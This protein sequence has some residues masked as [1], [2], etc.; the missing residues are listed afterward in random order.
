M[1][2]ICYA[3][4]KRP[5]WQLCQAPLYGS[6]GCLLH[7]YCKSVNSSWWLVWCK[8]CVALQSAARTYPPWAPFSVFSGFH[9]CFLDLIEELMFFLS[10]FV[11]ER[12][13]RVK[14]R[15]AWKEGFSI[16]F[17]GRNKK[18]REVW[19]EKKNGRGRSSLLNVQSAGLTYA[20]GDIPKP[21][22]WLPWF[23][24]LHPWAA[25]R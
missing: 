7:S 6:D 15:L 20:G 4:N 24:Q 17:G 8:S 23:P 12:Y 21:I 10:C 5:L 2:I 25:F 11:S 3:L 22:L 9:I 19:V 13:S 18:G 14:E 16:K 1:H